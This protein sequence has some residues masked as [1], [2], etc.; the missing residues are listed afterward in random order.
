MYMNKFICSDAF[1]RRTI[2][3]KVESCIGDK[4]IYVNYYYKIYYLFPHY[5][6]IHMQQ[7]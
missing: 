1:V 2:Q 6:V 7:D 5:S 3:R 4:Y